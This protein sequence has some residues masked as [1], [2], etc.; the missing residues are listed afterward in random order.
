MK[1]KKNK[2]FGLATYQFCTSSC[3]Y[4]ER[5]PTILLLIAIHKLF[6]GLFTKFG[7]LSSTRSP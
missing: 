5:L 1:G 6:A 3:G 2:K 4:V 7:I